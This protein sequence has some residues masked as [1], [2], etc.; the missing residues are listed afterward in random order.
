MKRIVNFSKKKH[1]QALPNNHMHIFNVSIKTAKFGE[2]QPKGVRGVDDTKMAPST[3][4][5][6][7]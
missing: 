5:M 6:L 1:C 4:K 3:Q 2:S 7:K